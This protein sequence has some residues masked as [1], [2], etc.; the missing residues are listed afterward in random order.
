MAGLVWGA[1]HFGSGR[2]TELDKYDVTG[3][4]LDDTIVIF[5]IKHT[6]NGLIGY[7]D[8][9]RVATLPNKN[10]FPGL[11]GSLAT[12]EY[13]IS[14]LDFNPIGTQLTRSSY[15][16]FLFADT[17]QVGTDSMLSPSLNRRGEQIQYL[18]MYNE[19]G[20]P[21]KLGTIRR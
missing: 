8:G 3:D 10:K 6:D 17:I 20:A 11:I 7:I 13:D 21:D 12:P 19:F 1:G 5:P 9:K 4:G 15:N 16:D 2:V 18:M 14:F